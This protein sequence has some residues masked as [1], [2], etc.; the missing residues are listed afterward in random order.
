MPIL[1]LQL[2]RKLKKNIEKSRCKFCNFTEL[3]IYYQLPPVST[4]ETGGLLF[5]YSSTTFVATL[6][7]NALSCSTNRIVGWY[8]FSTASICIR[9]MMSM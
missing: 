5:V 8:S 2:C 4:V 3:N 1:L 9:E 7:Q 6:S